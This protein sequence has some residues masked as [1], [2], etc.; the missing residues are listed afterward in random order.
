MI[1][2]EIHYTS[3]NETKFVASLDLEFP[4]LI[5]DEVQIDLGGDLGYTD[6]VVYHRCLDARNLK[7]PHLEIHTRKS[8]K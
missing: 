5:G 7:T 6:V 3:G 2:T 8:E 4:L 1:N